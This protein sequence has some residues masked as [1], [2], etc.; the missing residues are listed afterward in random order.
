MGGQQVLVLLALRTNR[1]LMV[2][3]V[4]IV[5]S[6]GAASVLVSSS[7]GAWRQYVNAHQHMEG[8]YSYSFSA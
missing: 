7:V 4:W 1:Y 3:L 5:P 6:F 8:E 2:V